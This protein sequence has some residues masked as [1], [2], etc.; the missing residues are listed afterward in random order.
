MEEKRRHRRK[1]HRLSVD[2]AD[3]RGFCQRTISDI[4][5]SGLFVRTRNPVPLGEVIT[6]C[7]QLGGKSFRIRGQVVRHAALGMGLKFIGRSEDD[8]RVVRDLVGRL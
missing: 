3:G 6:L 4:S 2:Y 7:F 5:Y 8:L 1:Q